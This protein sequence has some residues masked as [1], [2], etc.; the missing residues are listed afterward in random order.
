MHLSILEWDTACKIRLLCVSGAYHAHA[1]LIFGLHRFLKDG[2]AMWMLKLF[3][4]PH[5]CVCLE[6]TSAFPTAGQQSISWALKGKK[7]C[8]IDW[9]SDIHTVERLWFCS[10]QGSFNGP[11][12]YH[13]MIKP[14]IIS[15]QA[16][17]VFMATIVF[18]SSLW[19]RTNTDRYCCCDSHKW[20]CF[21][22]GGAT[23]E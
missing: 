2:V 11:T 20:K 13:S 8:T 3:P 6:K 7:I 14:L 5:L 4:V 19:R 18:T 21:S 1:L 23:C 16:H 12:K 9:E 22:L 10:S 15:R 17:H